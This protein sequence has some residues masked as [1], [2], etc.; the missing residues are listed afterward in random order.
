MKFLFP[1][2]GEGIHEAKL[3]N[4]HKNQ[5]DNIK[6][7]EVL[8]EVETDK[9]VVEIPSPATG[10]IESFPHNVGDT[11][12]VGDMLAEISSENPSPSTTS[13][14]QETQS[15]GNVVGSLE[16]ADTS[17]FSEIDFSN[18]TANTTKQA[19][20]SA[21][22][23]IRKLARDNNI[24]LIDIKTQGTVSKKE[25]EDFIAQKA[26]SKQP[27]KK[28][29]QEAATTP[30][31]AKETKDSKASVK[32]NK[33]TIE[34]SQ[35]RKTIS[36]RMQESLQ[37]TAQV[38][39]MDD[40]GIQNIIQHR[41][42][43]KQEAQEQGVKLTYLPYFIKSLIET[44]KEYPF[45][46]A[47]YD[48][49]VQK[50]TPIS[51]FHIAIAVDTPNGLMVPVIKNAENYNLFG[52]AKVI[53]KLTQKA[54]D[55]SL[56]VADQTGST[57]TITNYGSL[58]TKYATPILNLPNTANLGIGTFEEKLIMHNEEIQAQTFVP[59]SLTY[60]HDVIDGGSAARFLQT[61]KDKLA[62]LT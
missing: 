9:S 62:E 60:A 59:I 32:T 35:T 46:N 17:K 21:L 10:I 33:D 1:D 24:E 57:I 5:G 29:S 27:A 12:H 8:C 47:E 56:S 44:L 45:F 38:T 16:D 2:V 58:G 26:N 3:V 43:A 55:R 41:Q 36:K 51:E 13:D 50:L 28:T 19:T 30:A 4:I 7:D 37:T 18:Y 14:I 6:Q 52:L 20:V 53:Q 49:S 11:I 25:L 61:F 34:L 39:Q 42:A 15:S 31:N 54:H 40:I 48:S 23:Q 22:P